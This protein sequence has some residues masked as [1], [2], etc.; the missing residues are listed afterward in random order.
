MKILF[1]DIVSEDAEL[2]V[3]DEVQS[4]NCTDR[5]C[6]ISSHVD[7]QIIVFLRVGDFEGHKVQFTKLNNPCECPFI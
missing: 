3:N 1:S 2:I 6:I 7:A 4:A 5:H